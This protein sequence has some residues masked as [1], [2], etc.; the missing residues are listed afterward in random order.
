MR[1]DDRANLDGARAGADV[2][3]RRGRSRCMNF[4]G[5]AD[6]IAYPQFSRTSNGPV[7]SA[8]ATSRQP[9]LKHS[10]APRS[11]LAEASLPRKGRPA[12]CVAPGRTR[13]MGRGR[14]GLRSGLRSGRARPAASDAAQD[15]RAVGNLVAA[16]SASLTTSEY[17]TECTDVQSLV[18]W[19]PGPSL[20]RPARPLASSVKVRAG[21]VSRLSLQGGTIAER[22]KSI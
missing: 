17:R 10:A 19:A 15:A 7:M 3:D 6:R 5:F 14:A 12:A 8:F 1:T 4:I 21:P 11:E 2:A 18:R 13:P 9:G 22:V 16:F 20:Q